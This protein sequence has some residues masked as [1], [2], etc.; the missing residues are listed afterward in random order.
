MNSNRSNTIYTAS[1][2][3]KYLSGKLSNTERHE[4]EKAALD[5]PFLAEAMEGYEIMK[6]SNWNT[7]LA[8][9]RRQ[10]ADTNTE[11][12]VIPMHRTTGRWWK[13][14]AAVMVLGAAA[15]LTYV[16]T[17][18][19]ATDKPA[20]ELAQTKSAKDTANTTKS[21][22]ASGTV[23][24]ISPTTEEQQD[25]KDLASVTDSKQK[26]GSK[27]ENDLIN[28][29]ATENAANLA[30]NDKPVPTNPA[31]QEIAITPPPPPDNN[32]VNNSSTAAAEMVKQNNIAGSAKKHDQISTDKKEPELNHNFIAQVVTPDNSSLPF[33]NITIRDEN[34]GTYADVKGNFRLVSTDSILT[35][36]VRSVGYLPKTYT[37]RSDHLQNKIV[38][39]E[40]DMTAKNKTV[41]RNADVTHATRTRRATLMADSI[42]NAEP[43]DGWDN[44]NTYIANNID[45]HDEVLNKGLHGEVR[46]TFDVKPDG[47]ITNIRVD[48]SMGAE[49][50]EL[51]RKLI[52]Q[53]PQWKVKKGKKTSAS[54]KVKF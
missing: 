54:V 53:G 46:I 45:I 12:K 34:F 42:I 1:D 31:W 2:I 49:Y 29:R 41:V 18:D 10:V 50:D 43:A 24:T 28:T 15:I 26:P 20:R 14:A 6:G 21:I 13:T 37:L 36:E 25:N 33:S 48:K 40:D 7:T 32:P 47:A 8:T 23:T 16:F 4:M 9:L 38:L 39:Q 27:E 30:K 3:E 17:K 22:N 44:Y 5:D 51:A 52:Q 11:A 19:Q 35:I